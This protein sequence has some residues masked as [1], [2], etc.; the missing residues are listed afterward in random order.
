MQPIK[1]EDKILLSYR[2]EKVYPLPVITIYQTCLQDA[3]QAGV[4]QLQSLEDEEPEDL[5]AREEPDRTPTT[6]RRRIT[7]DEDDNDDHVN[8]EDGDPFGKEDDDNSSLDYDQEEAQQLDQRQA[9][10]L[11]TTPFDRKKARKIIKKKEADKETSPS[12]PVVDKEHSRDDH[13]DPSSLLHDEDERPSHHTDSLQHRR[14]SIGLR[15][16]WV[17]LMPRDTSV[18]NGPPTAKTKVVIFESKDWSLPDPPSRVHENQ[19][20][21]DDDQDNL[22][23]QD[24]NEDALENRGSRRKKMLEDEVETER[25]SEA[26]RHG[27]SSS[28]S[29]LSSTAGQEVYTMQHVQFMDS[30]QVLDNYRKSGCFFS[31]RGLSSPVI[32]ELKLTIP[33]T[34]FVVR[35]SIEYF[36]G[37]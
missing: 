8:D 13:H 1:H 37:E 18:F 9:S 28:S 2:V 30:V 32:F 5:Q 14:R 17:P 21:E 31:N 23:S 15:L 25:T 29:L 16:E 20:S 35:K 12:T 34:D 10:L 19:D 33:S 4:G 22:A 7:K 3:S 24:D 11:K 26:T 27:S 36:P 6:P